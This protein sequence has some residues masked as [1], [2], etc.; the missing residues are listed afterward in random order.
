MKTTKRIIVLLAAVLIVCT[1]CVSLVACHRKLDPETRPF[2]MSISQP[3]GVFNPFFST[4][5]YDSSIIS[6]TQIG[7][8]NTDKDGKIVYG[9][10]EPTVTKDYKETEN[11]NANGVTEST[12]YEFLIKKGIK[13]SDGEP[14]TIS[15]V[16]FSIYVY[17]DPSYTGSATIYSTDIIGLKNY[18]LQQEGNVSG[19]SVS[20][21]ESQFMAKANQRIADLI[22][23]VGI[24][25]FYSGP[26][27]S[28]PTEDDLSKDFDENQALVDIAVVAREFFKE[29]TSD[30]NAINKDDYKDWDGFDE[31]WKIFLLNDG[32]MTELLAKKP[33]SSSY[34]KDENGNF[35]IDREAANIVYDENIKPY[36]DALVAEGKLDMSKDEKVAEA[37]KDCCIS[38]VFDTY[39]PEFPKKILND[40]SDKFEL[41]DQDKD[42][43]YDSMYKQLDSSLF[44]TVAQDWG[45]ASVIFDRFKAEEKSKFFADSQRVVPNVAGIK[46]KKVTSFNGKDLGSEYDVL[47]ITIDGVDPKAKYNFS[48]LVSPMHYYSGEWNGKDY[49]KAALDDFA[50]NGQNGLQ[51]EF[52]V[53]FGNSTFM[54]EVVNATSKIGLPL[55]AGPYMASTENGGRAN[56]GS[57]FFTNNMVYY[58]RNPYFETVGAEL[59]NAKIKTVRYKVVESDQ[60]INSLINGDIDFGDPG[61]TIDNQNAIN[62]AG[63]PSVTTMTSGYGYVGINPRFVPDVNVRR[64][65]IKAMDTSIIINN[66]YHELAKIIKRPISMASWAYP[67]DSNDYVSENGTSYEYDNFGDDIEDMVYD[68]GYRKGSDGV[69]QRTIPGFGVDKLDYKFTIAGGS[70]DHPAY[71]MFLRAQTILNKHGFNV[72]VVTSQT[73]LTDLSAGK[74]AVW[75]AAWSS[76]IDPDMYQTYHMESQASSVKNWGYSQIIGRKDSAAWSDE[77]DIIVRLSEKIDEGRG[78]TVEA[79]RKGIYADALDLIMELACEFPTYQRNDL[80]AYQANMLD[81]ATLPSAS[82]CTSYSGLLARIWEINYIK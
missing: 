69:Y 31:V 43:I 14:L 28:K 64:A 26:I 76:T 32:G 68:A 48:F 67:K 71:D 56:S 54:N 5:A 34:D 78:T 40:K 75:A 30:W 79:E 62:S 46:T 35:K 18:R 44:E 81:P 66:Y 51:S 22:T 45:T 47:S 80:S 65:I 42:D 50:A 2:S 21:F 24:H 6:L 63:L 10:N 59:S 20:N 52:G 16:L 19:E 39:F 33:G 38:I 29:L 36:L 58:E 25:G 15:D 82:E 53:E 13:W 37:I 11:K 57:Q 9:E 70:T 60:I 74:L 77:Y 73:A 3:D 55:G 4:S 23:Y 7:M 61:A 12:T 17:L 27:A 41:T 49:V 1:L 8:L 72:K